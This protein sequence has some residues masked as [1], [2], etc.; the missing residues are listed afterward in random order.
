MESKKTFKM[1]ICIRI[2]FFKLGVF[3]RSV[4]DWTLNGGVVPGAPETRDVL[5]FQWALC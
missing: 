4:R 2:Q 1:M 3:A 5:S